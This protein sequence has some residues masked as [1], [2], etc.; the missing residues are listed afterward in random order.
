MTQFRLPTSI[1]RTATIRYI[2]KFVDLFL[3]NIRFERRIKK[4][5]VAVPDVHRC[6][7]YKK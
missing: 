5:P 1:T 6:N 3:P 7:R 2:S 4:V